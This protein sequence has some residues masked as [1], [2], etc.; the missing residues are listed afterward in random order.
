MIQCVLN[1]DRN[2]KFI[3]SR[4]GN[5]LP[6]DRFVVNATGCGRC[7]KLGEHCPE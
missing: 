2:S 7:L 3:P 6:S 4:N 1:L 5:C